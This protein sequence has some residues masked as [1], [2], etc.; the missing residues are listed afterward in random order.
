MRLLGSLVVVAVVVAP[1]I[2]ALPLRT[3]DANSLQSKQLVHERSSTRLDAEN[4]FQK[5]VIILATNLG[6]GLG[7][8][9]GDAAASGV[10]DA[11]GG[12]VG[13]IKNIF[14]GGS[15]PASKSQDDSSADPVIEALQNAV[16]NPQPGIFNLIG[17]AVGEWFGAEVGKFISQGLE[18]NANVPAITQFIDEATS[19]N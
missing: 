11:V 14:D 3:N 6:L 8:I 1:S 13:D 19:K 16:E 5:R 18:G 10:G 4:S 9:I 15:A 12:A 17:G 7:G 2:S